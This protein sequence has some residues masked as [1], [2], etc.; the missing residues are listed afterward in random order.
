MYKNIF[1]QAWVTTDLDRA[2]EVFREEQGIGSIAVFKDFGL[3]VA[4][5]EPLV[6]D[7]GLCYVGDLQFE[8]IQ[9]VSGPADLYRRHLPDSGDFA[10]KYHHMCSVLDS[11]EEYG[12]VLEDYR[13][14]GVTIEV[15]G[16]FGDGG[17]FFYADTRDAVDHYQEYVLLDEATNEF[18]ASLPRN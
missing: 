2:V 5:S 10:L 8:I 13:R 3:P 14:R 17:R 12:R 7:V 11:A 15:E 1:Q 18:M 6:I 16:G 9:P 4:D